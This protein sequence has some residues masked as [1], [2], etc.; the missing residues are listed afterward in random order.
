MAS[1]LTLPILTQGRVVGSVNLYA[2]SG[3][4]FTGVHEPLADLLS[5]WAPGAV[6]NADL[7]FSTRRLAEESPAR[8]RE[9]ARFDTAVGLHAA[10]EAL[11]V[12]EARERLVMAAERGGVSL[13]RIAQA[14]I[15]YYS[16]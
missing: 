10:E 7:S 1:T 5:A 8:L 4:A 16:R 11:S 3:H 6:E 15:T 9:L 2:G 12:E 13:S 14:V